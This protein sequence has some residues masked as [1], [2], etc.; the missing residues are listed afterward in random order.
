MVIT[1]SLPVTIDLPR[2][3]HDPGEHNFTVVA[4]STLGERAEFTH[5]FLLAGN[6]LANTFKTCH[7]QLALFRAFSAI[8]CVQFIEPGTTTLTCATRFAPMGEPVCAYRQPATPVPCK[9]PMPPA[10]A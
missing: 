2:F 9:L 6:S 1:G 5:L 4:N 3:D 10:I 7:V 8:E